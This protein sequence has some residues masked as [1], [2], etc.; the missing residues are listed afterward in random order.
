MENITAQACWAKTV[1]NMTAI[2]DYTSLFCQK[3]GTTKGK[4][5]FFH[6][7][8]INRHGFVE[9]LHRSNNALRLYGCGINSFANT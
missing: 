8:R 6:I 5:L 7:I 9:R 3:Y 2:F 1:Q 4:L